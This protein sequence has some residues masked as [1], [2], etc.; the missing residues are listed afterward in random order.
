MNEL[1]KITKQT[2]EKLGIEFL[3]YQEKMKPTD[4]P[5]C[6][7][8]FEDTT[9]D[10]EYTFFRF[11][12]KGVGYVGVLT[13]VGE[14]QRNYATLLPSY[15]EGFA[16]KETELSKTE[17]LKR[18]LLG[19][20]STLG[21]HKY[22]SKFSVREASCY[23]LSIRVPKM[24]KETVSVIEQ[25]VGNSLDTVVQMGADECVLVKYVDKK[26]NEY[27]SSVDYAEFLAQSLKEELGI[28]VT[29]GVGPT[30]RD[31]KDAAQSY[32]RA[33]TTLRYAET[34]AADGGVYSYREF[35]LVKMLEDLSESKLNEYLS[36]LT[37]DN[38]REILEN[39]E[40][41]STAEEFLRSNL[42]VSETSRNLY[43]HRNTLLYR[44][45]K[46][47]KATGLN[48]RV[49]SDAVSFR[50]LTLIYHLLGK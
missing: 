6:E 31:I 36:D 40:I 11:L 32:A 1:K 33:V 35:V 42:N 27:Q 15:I 50:V 10:G 18:I 48:I 21:I 14:T 44:L 2:A 38:F 30:V 29:I 22:A 49:F 20:C 34:L 5:V 47:E 37:D 7:K 43:M 8:S 12:F 4:V 45:D 25:Y 16:D 23:A 26:E 9:D 3:Y 17:Y 24:L 19:E 13:G 39:E 46:I 28:H 41:L